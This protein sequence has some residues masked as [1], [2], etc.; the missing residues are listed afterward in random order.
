MLYKTN[1]PKVIVR[2]IKKLKPLKYNKFMWWRR[3]SSKNIPLPKGAKFFDKI[4]Y[5]FG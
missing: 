2:E 3:F 1:D 5:I 4:K